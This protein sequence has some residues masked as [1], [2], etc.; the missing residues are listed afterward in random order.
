MRLST[1][2]RSKLERESTSA[3]KETGVDTP[4]LVMLVHAGVAMHVV[5][6]EEGIHS[7]RFQPANSAGRFEAFGDADII[8]TLT[9][10]KINEE[11]EATPAT[12]LKPLEAF[13]CLS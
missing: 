8:S 2:T 10:G 4:V 7:A 5:C 12:L 6:M 9:P 1:T 11:A 13:L 3:N